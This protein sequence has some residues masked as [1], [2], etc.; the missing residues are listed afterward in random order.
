MQRTIL[1][2]GTGRD[3]RR[4][5]L[6]GDVLVISDFKDRTVEKS[7][8][9]YSQKVAGIYCEKPGIMGSTHPLDDPKQ[10][11]IPLAV[12][13]I[14]PCKVTGSIKRGD[15]LTT[16]SIAGHAM[17][18]PAPK[19]GTILGKAFGEWNVGNGKIDV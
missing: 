3:K 5:P 4:Q 14:V 1:F 10:N 6:P 8:A 11:E 2:C 12:S 9:P 18:H 17:K 7:A 13:G 19:V 16:S 15:L